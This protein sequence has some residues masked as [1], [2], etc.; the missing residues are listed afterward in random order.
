MPS[1]ATF[2]QNPRKFSRLVIRL[3]VRIW[4][5]GESWDAETADL[6]A[7]GCQVV[8]PRP[9]GVGDPVRLVITLVA[10]APPVTVVGSVAWASDAGRIRLG[11]VFADRQP[12]GDPAAWFRRLVAGQPGVEAS[13]RRVPDRL[14]AET[15]L[16]LR[17]PPRFILDFGPD[18]IVLLRAIG[19]GTTI[20]SLLRGGVFTTS[21]AA[22]VIF[23][24]L[25][26]RIITLALGEAVPG[27]KWAAALA[28][29]ESRH[30]EAER[31]RPR[32]AGEEGTAP[33][34]RAAP[35]VV[36]TPEAQECYELAVAAVG[37]GEIS[38]AIGLLRRSL[39]LT[40]RDP[41]VSA[42]LGQL[43]FR[44]RQPKPG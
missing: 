26:K 7:T 43:A 17:T 3:P 27:W 39:Q 28:D 15:R 31:S 42:L 20:G 13:M 2:V 37:M 38:T 11:I 34:S 22:R 33:A 30:G 1:V 9:V 29:A 4:R 35:P 36:R 44:D 6:S 16:Y 8:T 21:Q 25:E 18:E 40:P 12:E 41:E 24:L 5:A 32:A 10:G 19:D 14:P 23:T